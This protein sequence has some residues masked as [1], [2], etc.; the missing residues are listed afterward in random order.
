MRRDLFL[1]G[2]ENCLSMLTKYTCIQSKR[3][4]FD[5]VMSPFLVL[6]S[7]MTKLHNSCIKAPLHSPFLSQGLKQFLRVNIKLHYVSNRKLLRH[8][9]NKIALK[10]QVIYTRDICNSER[11]KQ[12]ISHVIRLL[13]Q[14][15]AF[16][17]RLTSHPSVL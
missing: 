13:T 3:L 17:T 10:S 1:L 9:S 14:I 11:D 12:I 8:R 16:A 7:I 5:I 2:E 6:S 4:L 15:P